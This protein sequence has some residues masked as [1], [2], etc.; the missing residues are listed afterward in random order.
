LKEEQE[1]FDNWKWLVGT[2]WIVPPG[3]LS[4]PLFSS[5]REEPVW[6]SDQT[7][8]QITGAANGYF[9]GNT[10]ALV[11][12]PGTGEDAVPAAQRLMASVTP[13]GRVHITFVPVDSDGDTA[14]V[15]GIGNMRWRDGQW[16][17]E[18]QMSTPFGAS[19]QLLHWAYMVQCTPEDAAWQQ[20][21]GTDQS[22]PEFLEA[23]GFTVG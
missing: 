10:A 3:N 22:L 1:L 14:E 12:P 23:A 4:A 11:R 9:W 7:V 8:W 15:I 6:F 19:G 20:L 18:M 21:P 16:M 5:D 2:Y 13:E 17:A